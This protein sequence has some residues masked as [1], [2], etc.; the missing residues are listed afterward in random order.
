[1]SLIINDSGGVPGL[2]PEF[3]DPRT[4]GPGAGSVQVYH[5]EVSV[6]GQHLDS[7]L[8][9]LAFRSRPQQQRCVSSGTDGGW[10]LRRTVVASA[11]VLPPAEH[12]KHASHR[13]ACVSQGLTAV[14]PLDRIAR[15]SWSPVE[16]A[17]KGSIVGG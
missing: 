5:H 3:P 10:R 13:V 15:L 17:V 4:R 2:H 7:V 1:M 14:R 9:G 16:P 12:V 6:V 11:F 8:D